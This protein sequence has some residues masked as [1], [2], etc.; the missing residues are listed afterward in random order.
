MNINLT[1]YEREHLE[2][3]L[4]N[5]TD[6]DSELWGGLYA[7]VKEAPPDD[8]NTILDRLS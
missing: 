3:L 1:D 7:K 4:E 2:I 8:I 5:F 6:L